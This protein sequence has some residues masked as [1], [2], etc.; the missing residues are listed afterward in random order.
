MVLRTLELSMVIVFTNFAFINLIGAQNVFILVL[1]EHKEMVVHFTNFQTSHQFFISQIIINAVE[2]WFYIKCKHLPLY[3]TQR[4]NLWLF[5][6]TDFK[7]LYHCPVQHRFGT[8][9]ARKTQA[10][11][12]ENTKVSDLSLF[13]KDFLR[14]GNFSNHTFCQV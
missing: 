4:Q 10:T 2:K 6:L 3:E 12:L 1:H 7:F 13:L 11:L 14:V 5:F 9:L 8:L